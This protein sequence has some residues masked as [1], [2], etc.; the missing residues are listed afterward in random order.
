M[1]IRSAVHT[2]SN[3]SVSAWTA[4]CINVSGLAALPEMGRKTPIFVARLLT[5][6]R[7][8]GTKNF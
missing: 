3:P 5:Q 6:A 7:G 8:P 1:M 2:E 4:A